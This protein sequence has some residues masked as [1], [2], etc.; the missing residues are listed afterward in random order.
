M[1]PI[2]E[3]PNP[4]LADSDG[5]VGIGGDLHPDSLLLAY[6]QGIFPWPM[7]G[8]PLVWFCP[9][10]RAILRFD[11]LHIGRTLAKVIKKQNYRF[12]VNRAFKEVISHCRET[13]KGDTWIT[14]EMQ[15]AYIDFHKVGYAHSF[16]VWNKNGQLVGG[17]YGVGVDGFFAGESMFHLEDNTSKLAIVYAVQKLQKAHVH[18]MDIQMITPHLKAM[19]AQSIKREPF[20]DLLEKTRSHSKNPKLHLSSHHP[21]EPAE[22]L[23]LQKPAA[24]LSK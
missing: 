8:Y 3:F 4:R 11:H 21:S 12:S 9:E 24:H 2:L 18:W 13:R 1:A 6:R 10:K 5:V 15:K 7:P 23:L 20:L 19:G 14:K 22:I 16:E 17:L